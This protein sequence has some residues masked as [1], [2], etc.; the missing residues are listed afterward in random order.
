MQRHE[1][2]AVRLAEGMVSPLGLTAT[3]DPGKRHSSIKIAGRGKAHRVV[4]AGSPRGG[5]SEQ[6]SYTRQHITRWLRSEGLI[7]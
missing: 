3:F 2:E 5:S 4:L 6:L 7:S 1:R